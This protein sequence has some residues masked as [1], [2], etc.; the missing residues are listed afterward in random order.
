MSDRSTQMPLEKK[1]HLPGTKFYPRTSHVLGLKYSNAAGEKV[2]FAR[3]E[4]LPKNF[5]CFGVKFI[6][7][8]IEVPSL[9]IHG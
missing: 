5:P 6:S 1:S 2:P 3:Y 4:I 8:T 7:E 9:K